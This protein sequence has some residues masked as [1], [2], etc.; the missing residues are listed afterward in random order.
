MKKASIFAQT[1]EKQENFSIFQRSRIYFLSYIKQRGENI[2]LP[3]PPS[4]KKKISQ[5]WQE[6]FQQQPHV[7]TSACREIASWTIRASSC[8]IL[9]KFSFGEFSLW[10]C[11]ASIEINVVLCNKFRARTRQK[12]SPSFFFF[13][14][15]WCRWATKLSYELPTY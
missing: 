14:I 11:T 7:L 10:V 1:G 2:L 12:I 5:T 13:S 6:R 8:N 9:R 3:P 4:S 15:F